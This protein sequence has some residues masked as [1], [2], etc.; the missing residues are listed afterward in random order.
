MMIRR[1]FDR[2]TTRRRT[3]DGNKNFC[4]KINCSR[5]YVKTETYFY[6]FSTIN[7]VKINFSLNAR[8][9]PVT[10]PFSLPLLY[11]WRSSIKHV[12][13]LIFHFRRFSKSVIN[14]RVPH[15]TEN[16]F[17]SQWSRSGRRQNERREQS[18]LYPFYEN[19][20]NLF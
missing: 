14:K 7:R 19:V 5:L 8:H 4:I 20:Y 6:D 11:S 17:S 15:L 13:T 10:L 18:S 1:G 12:I 3:T 2:T 9:Y 16:L